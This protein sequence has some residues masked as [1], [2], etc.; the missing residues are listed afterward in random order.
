M[1][2]IILMEVID[3]LESLSKEPEGFG[4]G[5]DSLCVLVVEQI[6]VLGVFHDHVDLAIFEESVPQ[7][8]D[9]G[10]VYYGVEGYLS[11]EEFEFGFGGNILES[12][13]LMR[14][15]GTILMA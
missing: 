3:T 13:L 11:L 10:V 6:A 8:Y 2:D 1:N 5:E 12:Y 4:L 14:S 7:F 9:M 15:R